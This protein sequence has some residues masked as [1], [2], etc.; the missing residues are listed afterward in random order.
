LERAFAIMERLSSAG[1]VCPRPIRD[2]AG[3]VSIRV[4][5][6]LVAAVSFLPGVTAP[7]NSVDRCVE[8]GR[9]MAQIHRLLPSRPPFESTPLQRGYIHG[10]LKPGN[11]LFVGGRV[12]GVINFRLVHED[13]FVAEIADVI[14]HWTMKRDGSLDMQYAQALMDGYCELRRL[15]T[16]DFEALPGFIFTSSAKL[17]SI[18]DPSKLPQGP[19]RTMECGRSLRLRSGWA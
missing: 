19:E 17:F 5:G 14:A 10:A 11:V 18:G 13:F 7:A 15:D 3:N 8:L 4:A 16:A 9:H 2:R 1:F 6:K 12:T